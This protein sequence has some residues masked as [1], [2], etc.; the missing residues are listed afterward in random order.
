LWSAEATEGQPGE[1]GGDEMSEWQPIETAPGDGTRL[2]VYFTGAGPIV[3]F[4][5]PDDGDLWIRYIGYGK[6]R[7]WPSI[8]ADYATHWQPLPE[9]PL[10]DPSPQ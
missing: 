9:P 7:L 10:S 3:A 4:R 8:H 1:D 6:S 5:T 2:L